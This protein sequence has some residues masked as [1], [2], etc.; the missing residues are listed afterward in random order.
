MA[1]P[2]ASPAPAAS[3]SP[4][5]PP[6]SA[7]TPKKA[8]SSA[9]HLLAPARNGRLQHQLRRRGRIGWNKRRR[10]LRYAGTRDA[11]QP[12]LGA[13]AGASGLSRRHWQ[14]QNATPAVV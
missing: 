10:G 14:P 6:G 9:T 5:T 8:I 4:K 7:A 12:V 1:H 11:D 2:P 13:D 3:T